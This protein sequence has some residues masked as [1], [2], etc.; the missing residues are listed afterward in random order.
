M[1]KILASEQGG[2]QQMG[3]PG[4]YPAQ[5]ASY[6]NHQAPGQPPYQ[7]YPMQQV[8]CTDGP[9]RALLLLLIG[10]EATIMVNILLLTLA[11]I[12]NS[13]SL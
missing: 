12:P 13:T 3:Y 6:Q 7:A 5:P 11:E 8:S 9:F 1:M 10:G 2:G 4:P